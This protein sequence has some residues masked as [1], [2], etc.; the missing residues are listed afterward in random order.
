MKPLLPLVVAAAVI[1]GA[2][3]QKPPTGEGSPTTS[4]T[5]S[6]T[7][8]PSPPARTGGIFR[9]AL[10]ADACALDPWNVADPNSLLA[11]RQ[12]FETLVEYADELSV[13]PALAVEQLIAVSRKALGYAPHAIGAEPF[14]LVAFGR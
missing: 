6:P 4:P 1:L 3:E 12:V 9:F 5:A 13:V 2:C 11:T 10:A 7:T 8:A 14:T